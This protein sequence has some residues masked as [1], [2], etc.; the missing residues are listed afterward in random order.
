MSM[1][2]IEWLLMHTVIFMI[3]NCHDKKKKRKKNARL[4]NHPE[5]I[6]IF[7]FQFTFISFLF[8]FFRLL[9][10]T[11]NIW[12]EKKNH[13]LFSTSCYL[14]SREEHHKI[15]SSVVCSLRSFCFLLR[16]FFFSSSFFFL[17]FFI[18]HH[19]HLIILLD[20]NKYKII[21]IIRRRITKMII[22]VQTK[23]LG[24]Q[25]FR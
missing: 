9:V 21:I 24:Y 1:S 25:W 15:T 5:S 18:A 7:H 13:T 10:F 11:G 6:F 4:D 23:N 22:I 14:H 20:N 2:F 8:I 17:F 3:T 19:H 12:N 16:F